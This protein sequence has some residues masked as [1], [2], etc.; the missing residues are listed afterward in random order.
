VKAK[1]SPK[2]LEILLTDSGKG[3]YKV[4]TL[5]RTKDGDF[6][7]ESKRNDGHEPPMFFWSQGEGSESIHPFQTFVLSGDTIVLAPGTE[8]VLVKFMGYPSSRPGKPS[9]GRQT[10]SF[11]V[12]VAK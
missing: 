11:V 3:P 1:A 12:K 10:I 4:S 2:S 6:E 9:G 5:L 7:I 8:K